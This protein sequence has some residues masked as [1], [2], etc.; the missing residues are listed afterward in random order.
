[1]ANRKVYLTAEAELI[2]HV[3]EG[4]EDMAAVAAFALSQ[5][6]NAKPEHYDLP[7]ESVWVEDVQVGRVTVT[8]SK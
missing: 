1:M 7:P 5:D 2:V 8:D 6:P 3:D 4:V